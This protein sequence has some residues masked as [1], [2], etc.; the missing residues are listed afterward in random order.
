[1]LSKKLEGCPLFSH[2]KEWGLQVKDWTH[3]THGQGAGVVFSQKAAFVIQNEMLMQ[4]VTLNEGT[5][6]DGLF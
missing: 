1:M 3:Q 5:L 2:F 6:N 4:I